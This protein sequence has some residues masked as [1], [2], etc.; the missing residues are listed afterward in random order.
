[1]K[2]LEVRTSALQQI[3][4]YLEEGRKIQAIKTLRTSTQCNLRDAKLAAE[5]FGVKLG[6][7]DIS[8]ANKEAMIKP[9]TC[10]DRVIISVGEGRVEV[11]LEEAQFHIMR[12]LGIIPLS[13]TRRLLQLLEVLRRFSEGEDFELR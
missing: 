13:E 5:N 8:Y 3:R 1:M 4:T 10:I 2:I 12:E 11:D 9:A 7:L 6:L